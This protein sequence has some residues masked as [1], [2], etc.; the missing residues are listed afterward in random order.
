MAFKRPFRWNLVT[1]KLD[2]VV[3]LA[4][5][6]PSENDGIVADNCFRV[7]CVLQCASDAVIRQDRLKSTQDVC[8]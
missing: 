6:S 7:C 8:V 3:P 1:R 2:V 4:V 5:A